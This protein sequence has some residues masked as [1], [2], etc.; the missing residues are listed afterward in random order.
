MSWRTPVSLPAGW[1][2]LRLRARGRLSAAGLLLSCLLLVGPLPAG[3]AEGVS[4]SGRLSARA[5][6]ALDE[7]SVSEEP[8]MNGRLVVDAGRPGW[9]L[10]SW[11]E[12]GWD[13]LIA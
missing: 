7:S 4:V 11:L 6:C 10:Y 8:G 5:V 13:G 9:R 3:A 2:G 12:G 1:V